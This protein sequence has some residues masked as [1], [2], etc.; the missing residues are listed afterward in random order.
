MIT[1]EEWNTYSDD[2]KWLLLTLNLKSVEEY[3]QLLNLIPEC[4]DHGFCIPHMRQWLTAHLG[5]D[6][7]L[8]D[9][10]S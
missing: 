2:E 1:R 9:K 5:K 4:P 7:V 6:G 10:H 3:E 8:N